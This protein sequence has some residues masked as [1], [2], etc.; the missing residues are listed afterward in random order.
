VSASGYPLGKRATIG[1]GVGLV[2]VAGGAIVGALQTDE[3]GAILAFVGAIIVAL[4]TGVWTAVTTDRRQERQL[5]VAAADQRAAL[6]AE[7]SRQAAALEHERTLH[8]LGDVR[9]VI[10]AA[11]EALHVLE[12]AAIAARGLERAIG[13]LEAQHV[14]LGVRLDPDHNAAPECETVINAAHFLAR[15]LRDAGTSEGDAIAKLTEGGDVQ[16]VV[17]RATQVVLDAAGAFRNA[18]VDVARAR[19]PPKPLMR[20]SGNVRDTF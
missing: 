3:R 9:A 20:S 10:D 17:N 12:S 1:A 16:E 2:V 14:R 15:T 13:P 19:L 4:F 7:A 8:D 11:L 18:A 6:D 5:A